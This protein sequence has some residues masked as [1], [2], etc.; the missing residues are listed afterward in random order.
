MTTQTA[1]WTARI[2]RLSEWL[3]RAI[4]WLVVLMILVGAFNAVARYSSRFTGW[5]LSSNAYL[6]LQW[7]LFS[8]VFLLGGSYAL[9]RG[10]HVRVDVFYAR[11]GPRGQGTIDLLGTLCFLIP[12][13][14]A[15]VLLSLPSVRNAWSTWETSPDPGGLARYPIK[16]VL[17]VGF[18]L[19]LLQAFAEL[20]RSVAV[21]RGRSEA[22]RD[23]G[24]DHSRG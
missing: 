4:S 6:E 13:A 2:D 15:G 22:R 23:G 12:F 20:A 14:V 5:N 24:G 17:P 3:G 10:A 8:V 21:L 16:T 9:K 1:R 7:Y 11:L 18:A 19:L